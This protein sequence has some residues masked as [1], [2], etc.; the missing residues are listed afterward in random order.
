MP[1]IVRC[2]LI[3]AANVSPAKAMVDKHLGYIQQAAD[4][5][6][7]I[8]CLQEIFNGPYFCAE[9]E[10]RWYDVAGCPPSADCRKKVVVRE[11]PEDSGGQRKPS[12]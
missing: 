9:Q 4:A 7:Q 11:P 12:G 5:G 8:I 6:A 2:S 1:R 3:Q 10:T